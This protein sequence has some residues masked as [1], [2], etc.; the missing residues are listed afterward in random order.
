[1]I[2]TDGGTPTRGTSANVT[3]ELHNSC[4]VDEEFLNIFYDV[5]IG[6]RTGN[7]TVKV[8]GYFQEALGEIIFWFI[9]WRLKLSIRSHLK[10][11]FSW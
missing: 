3:I 2:V 4:L 5:I 9:D 7:V 10:Q 1:M 11:L 8:P 6:Y